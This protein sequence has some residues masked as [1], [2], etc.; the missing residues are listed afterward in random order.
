MTEQVYSNEPL[1]EDKE[2]EKIYQDYLQKCCEVGQIRYNL[3]QLHGQQLELEKNLEVTERAVKSAAHKHRE[4]Q[5]Q[6]FSKLKPA[7]EPK[8]ELNDK[9]AH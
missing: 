7:E 8:L 2:M 6:K 1:P 5:K 3:E 9:A 4:L